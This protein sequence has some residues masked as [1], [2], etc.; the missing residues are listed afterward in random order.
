MINEI[1]TQTIETDRLI[2]RRM[3]DEDALDMYNHWASDPL[4]PRYFTWDIH[5]NID[6]TKSLIKNWVAQYDDPFCFHWIIYCK[7]LEHT[8][9]TVYIDDIDR[10]SGNGV[11]SCIL[12][13]ECWGKGFAAEITKA[14]V[15]YAFEKAGFEKIFAHHHEDN[16][17]SGKA[18][19]KAGFSFVDKSYH[20]YDKE[21]INGTYFHYVI[22]K[23]N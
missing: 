23:L 12:S 5:E 10:E 20:S 16:I 4:V 15:N 8:I 17:A 22:E 13:R 14:V 2:L 18:L 21:S 1:G 7:E 19:L 11:I 3:T 6:V 9:G